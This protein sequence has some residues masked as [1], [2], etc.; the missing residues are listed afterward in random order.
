MLEVIEHYR[1]R[2]QRDLLTEAR[3]VLCP[4][5]III[6]SMPNMSKWWGIPYRIVWWLWERTVQREY[7][8]EHVGMIHRD[9]LI[10]LLRECGFIVL[11][12]QRIALLDL[13]VV[14]S[15]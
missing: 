1:G 3:R 14:C 11:Q 12:T 4:G 15:A 8:H 9:L 2:E 7:T 10:R 13:V 5:G 6:L